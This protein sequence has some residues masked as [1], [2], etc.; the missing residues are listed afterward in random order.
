MERGRLRTACNDDIIVLPVRLD[1]STGK[2]YTHIFY[3]NFPWAGFYKQHLSN[4]QT[5]RTC[6]AYSVSAFEAPPLCIPSS[7]HAFLAYTLNPKKFR[8]DLNH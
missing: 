8:P 7:I 6:V 5:L 1:E 4:K 3:R 2:K